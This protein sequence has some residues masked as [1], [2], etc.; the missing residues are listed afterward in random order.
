MGGGKPALFF[1]G[2]L[3]G[4]GCVIFCSA[5]RLASMLGVYLF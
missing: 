3:F 1:S 5:V 4:F 2:A